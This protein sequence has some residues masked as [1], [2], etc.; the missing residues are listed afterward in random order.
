MESITMLDLR[1][2]SAVLLKKLK[3][4]EKILLSFR[5]KPVATIH[6]ILQ[7]IDWESD[8]FLHFLNTIPKT[9]SKKKH[10]SNEEIDS[11]VYGI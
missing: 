9:S 3:R 6:P 8:S 7:D 1:K 5:G 2:N 11:L 4:K 10:L